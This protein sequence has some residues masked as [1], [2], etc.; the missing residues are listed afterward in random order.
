MKKKLKE[1][2]GV[3]EQV[4]IGHQVIV[5]AKNSILDIWQGSEYASTSS[6]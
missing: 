1:Q 5:F 4:K 6:L 2:S 3:A